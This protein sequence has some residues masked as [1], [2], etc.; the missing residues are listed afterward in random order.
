M[1]SSISYPFNYFVFIYTCC[2]H[3]L[4]MDSL[5]FSHA[6]FLSVNVSMK[7]LQPP[8]LFFF[9]GQ[10]LQILAVVQNASV[11]TGLQSHRVCETDEH[12]GGCFSNPTGFSPLFLGFCCL[13]LS[14]KILNRI[15][16]N[17]NSH[18]T[19]PYTQRIVMAHWR[20]KKAFCVC[21]IDKPTCL[22][23]FLRR[24]YFYTG[25]PICFC[26]QFLI[27]NTKSISFDFLKLM[28]TAIRAYYAL[29]LQQPRQL[30]SYLLCPRHQG[31]KLRFHW[32]LHHGS[33][34]RIAT[35]AAVILCTFL[36]TVPA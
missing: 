2:E 19:Y 10:S 13:V 21:N 23:M 12:G 8:P 27:M 18:N 16:V 9:F 1:F 28:R 11:S 14:S 3:I 29:M 30:W 33:G 26:N 25:L 24:L 6:L 15:K 35:N 17:N 22:L 7:Y 32:S 31:M 4:Y 20:K 34:A 36:P 5:S